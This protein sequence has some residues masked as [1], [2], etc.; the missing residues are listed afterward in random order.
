MVG[1]KHSARDRKSRAFEETR[2]L[3]NGIIVDQCKINICI[4]RYIE[5]TRQRDFRAKL[6][7]KVREFRLL[8]K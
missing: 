2:D 6:G 4:I 3:G 1:T 5:E 7:S 8:T